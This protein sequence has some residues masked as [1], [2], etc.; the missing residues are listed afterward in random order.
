[1]NRAKLINIAKIVGCVALVL[2]LVLAIVYVNVIYKAE[3]VEG[4]E[5]GEKCPDFEVLAYKT[6]GNPTSDTYSSASARGKVLVINFW[7]I[8]CG[9][10]V[11]ELPHF[12]EVQNEYSED[13]QIVVVH[14]HNVDTRLDKQENIER[15]GFGD[16][17]LTFVQDTAEL[18]LYAH[19]G[20]DGNFPMTIVLDKEGIIKSV[21]IGSMSKEDLVAEIEKC[22]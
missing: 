22:L 19:L 3:A 15:L 16:Y 1:M 18:N 2:I 11:A 7:Y 8:N 14:A 17:Q 21:N 10:C 13:V 5:I 12:N 9:G 4:Y 20:G 6:A